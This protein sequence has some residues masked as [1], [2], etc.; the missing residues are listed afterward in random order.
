MSLGVDVGKVLKGLLEY[1][2]QTGQH[3]FETPMR[4]EEE[5]NASRVSSEIAAVDNEKVVEPPMPEV[6][7]VRMWAVANTLSA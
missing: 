2:I 1:S 6:V 4:C 5:R 3:R 7:T